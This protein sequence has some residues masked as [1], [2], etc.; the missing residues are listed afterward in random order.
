MFKLENKKYFIVIYALLL[1]LF[2][3]Y[4]LYRAHFP[5]PDFEIAM[6]C[7]L[8]LAGIVSIIYYT[9]KNEELHKVAFVLIMT[10]GIISLFLTPIVDVSDESEHFVRSEIVSTGE[11]STDYVPIPNTTAYGYETINSV[12]I[13]FKNAGTNVFNTNV[14]DA[15]IDYSPT[16]ITFA[17]AQNP[18]Y[19]YL[20]QG[21]G[22]FLAKCLDLNAIW[23]LWLGRFFNLLLY[24]AIITLAIKKAPILKFQL[25][26]VSMLPLAIYQA[27]SISCDG[28][29]S[30]LAILAFAYFLY[31][32]KTP[33]ISWK[34]LTI[35]YI[36][37]V[38]CG[39]LKSPY[40]ALS[41]LIFLVPNNHFI[42]KKQ[43]IISKLCILLVLGIGLAWSSYA[44]TQLANSWRGEFFA[45]N[46]VSASGQ[47]EYLLSNPLIALQR[48]GE[49]YTTAL[50]TIVDRFFYFSNDVRDYSS[51]L[52][53]GL[54]FIFICLFSV[55]YPVD[56][57]FEL[58][59]RIKGFVICALIYGGVMAVQYLTWS[60][61][62]GDDVTRGVFSRYFMPLLIFLPFI[63]G[64]GNK[65]IDRKTL[66]VLVLT[67]SISFVS[68]MLML[69]TAVKY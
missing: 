34:D 66:D 26:V 13:F 36:A 29:F 2:S 10:F 12:D 21:L 3:A 58:K 64:I 56:E 40:L 43:N 24:G 25:L 7:I 14:D 42:D 31:F 69:T 1:S 18:F 67:I 49:T 15:K 22:V 52:L 54:Y 19:A 38:L 57:K 51:T 39:L 16:Y 11:L 41:L 35:F 62:G 44:T 47:I 63:F 45:K 55:F 61:V 46:N 4:F 17:F 59:P 32:Y 28:L 68:G 37:I 8:L 48:L 50:P 27:A 65:K 9:K 60:P 30:A 6:F 5:N 33:K 23:M 53:A 20:A